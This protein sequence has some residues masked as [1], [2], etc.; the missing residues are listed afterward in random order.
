MVD[1]RGRALCSVVNMSELGP[2]QRFPKTLYYALAG[3]EQ[4]SGG[5]GQNDACDPDRACHAEPIGS[6]NVSVSIATVTP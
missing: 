2:Q 5:R 3:D 6:C 4:R 1:N